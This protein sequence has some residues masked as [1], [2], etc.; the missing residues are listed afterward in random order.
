MKPNFPSIQD[1]SWLPVICLRLRWNR[2]DLGI[3]ATGAGNPRGLNPFIT[4]PRLMVDLAIP[5]HPK[6]Q[7]FYRFTIY[8]LRPYQCFETKKGD[9]EIANICFLC[10]LR[11]GTFIFEIHIIPSLGN[12][13]FRRRCV[14]DGE[15]RGCNVK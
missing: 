2:H 4:G 9:D 13:C 1:T 3:S 7:P 10:F 8:S 12:R 14:L 6:K 11:S 5:N 15:H